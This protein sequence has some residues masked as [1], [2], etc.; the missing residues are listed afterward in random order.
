VPNPGA[1]SIIGG[2]GRF[3]NATGSV[4]LSGAVNLSELGDG[5]ITFDCV[6]VIN[7]D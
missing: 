3:Q 5:V 4:R 2:T 6:F 7:L 1:N